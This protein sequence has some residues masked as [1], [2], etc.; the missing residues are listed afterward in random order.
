[1]AD[2]LHMPDWK[3]PLSGKV[4]RWDPTSQRYVEGEDQDE[5]PPMDWQGAGQTLDPAIHTV[6]P[7]NPDA[8]GILASTWSPKIG[9]R[10]Q[11]IV[12]PHKGWS[13]Y[14]GESGVVV[15][16]PFPRKDG[17]A[18]HV[19]F[20]AH[21]ARSQ[22]PT[23][24]LIAHL[25][26]DTPLT[27]P[28][29]MDP[30]AV[31]DVIPVD[32]H[33]HDHDTEE[34]GGLDLA[35]SAGL[36]G[37]EEAICRHCQQ[38]I[39]QSDHGDGWYHSKM[40]GLMYSKACSGGP[41]K[42]ENQPQA[43]PTVVPAMWHERD[44]PEQ[45]ANLV[46]HASKCPNCAHGTVG[47]DG[48]CE[49]CHY[50]QHELHEHAQPRADLG[51]FPD[52]VPKQ[53]YLKTD[54]DYPSLA[55]APKRLK[56]EMR[57]FPEHESSWEH[58]LREADASLDACPECGGSMVE[59]PHGA[60]CASCE[61]KQP[62]VTLG[63][64][65]TT[66]WAFLAPLA[67]AAGRLLLPLVARG[68]AAAAGSAAGGAAAGG[69]AGA[70][71]GAASGSLLGSMG[72]VM[73]GVS[74]GNMLMGGGQQPEQPAQPAPPTPTAPAA[75]IAGAKSNEESQSDFIMRGD[76][77]HPEN[78]GTRGFQ[79]QHSD[80]P[81][82]LKDVNDVGGTSEG[83][84]LPDNW[85]DE[86]TG[87]SDEQL[88][89]LKMFGENLD[90]IIVLADSDED[91]S[92]DEIFK[93]VD[94][95]LEAV[96]PGYKDH[97]DKGD[98][99]ESSVNIDEV[100]E[101]VAARRPK[102]CPAHTDLIDH[103]LLAGS[104]QFGS[105]A[106]SNYGSNY[107]K[108]PD[109]GGKCNFKPAM[110]TQKYW[111]DKDA[112]YEQRKLEREQAAEQQR[113]DELAGT[114]LDPAEHDVDLSA[115]P[116]AEWEGDDTDI[117]TAEYAPG[118]SEAP[119]AVGAPMPVA[120]KVASVE[121]GTAVRRR[122]LTPSHDDP[123]GV[124]VEL[125]TVHPSS[126]GRATVR[127]EGGHEESIPVTELE[128]ADGTG[129]DHPTMD[130]SAGG[131]ADP[132]ADMDPIGDPYGAPAG[133]A[134]Y[135]YASVKEAEHSD[136]DTAHVDDA[137][138]FDFGHGAPAHQSETAVA[139]D[140][141]NEAGIKDESGHPLKEGSTYLMAS[142]DYTVPDK[143]TIDKIAGSDITY[144]IHT[145]QMD[146]QDTLSVADLQLQKLTFKPVDAS[147]AEGSPG[148]LADDVPAPTEHQHSDDGGNL[149]DFKAANLAN[150]GDKAAPAFG[151]EDEEGKC[152]CAG[153]HE[154]EECVE[155]RRERDFAEGKTAS[156]DDHFPWHAPELSKTAGRDYSS[157][158]IRELIEEGEGKLAR[159]FGDLDL[160]QTHYTDDISN[161]DDWLY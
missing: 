64:R 103:S 18:I 4:M 93:S 109:F 132:A 141:E 47:V 6:R 95:A 147:P 46:R 56:D 111:D 119:S 140:G 85:V 87:M 67:A 7:K 20:D 161:T 27:I 78:D 44:T 40:D 156:L 96:F 80:A 116:T 150:F 76:D 143:V 14:K 79:E 11:L 15:G 159:N 114:T 69:A 112:E 155:D 75:M 106:P 160:T 151:S 128:P 30:D 61:L 154:C 54:H 94:A 37:S 137:D 74:M 104:P 36:S 59:G 45:R 133:Y 148:D 70:T 107:C 34:N 89:A 146:F 120:A 17:M 23:P 13:P 39:W 153:D 144:T 90:H 29:D 135:S 136:S 65:Q 129:T 53:N 57:A 100:L 43:E 115:E 113:A 142:P 91:N 42:N 121:I 92:A 22:H 82:F 31:G 131:G 28:V 21:D 158:E 16:E 71:G 68:G 125:T 9:D 157:R 105:F 99:K 110:T 41:L 149:S 63:G 32:L 124:V 138:Q 33:R 126:P 24:V 101:K 19:K 118:L 2:D 127:F 51:P 122:S 97:S 60:K 152:T 77:D 8:T 26:P 83:E 134:P 130:F 12:D 50:Q 52:R 98:K 49:Q 38:P 58:D 108:S 3:D 123:V 5:N 102:L 81:E 88:S 86:L 48:V 1:M 117:G 145:G 139:D 62:A 73:R 55:S 10:V 84:D 25:G 72:N 35:R 66:A